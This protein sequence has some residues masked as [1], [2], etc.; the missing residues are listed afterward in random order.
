MK[1]SNEEY[2]QAYNLIDN[3]KIM[4]SAAKSFRGQLSRDE[5]ESC[6]NY[7]LLKC[8]EKYDKSYNQKFTSSLYRFVKWCCLQEL[9]K[10]KRRIKT[11]EINSNITINNNFNINRDV[12]NILFMLS[13][14]DREI[15]TARFIEQKTFLEIGNQYGYTKQRARI[16]INRLLRKLKSGV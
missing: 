1:I 13:Q 16:I 15:L 12:Q 7:A 14:E 6:C 11:T 4:N 9:N 5:I 10:T 8:L 3:K 2:E